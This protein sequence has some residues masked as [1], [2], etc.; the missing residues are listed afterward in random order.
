[1]VGHWI[2]IETLDCN[3][4]WKEKIHLALLFSNGL[5][6]VPEH[7]H[8]HTHTH[9]HAHTYIHTYYSSF[10]FEQIDNFFRIVWFWELKT[11]TLFRKSKILLHSAWEG[12]EDVVVNV[13]DSDIVVTKLEPQPRYYVYFQ[14]NTPGKVMNP[15][16]PAG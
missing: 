15:F 11:R 5:E 3:I 6:H 4:L 12:E 2:R 13:L 8:T 9:T 14:K 10:V 16:M 1:M 7:T